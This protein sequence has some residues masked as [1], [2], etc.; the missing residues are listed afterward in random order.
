MERKG[1]WPVSLRVD[2]EP[3]GLKRV[4]EQGRLMEFVDAFST[5]AAGQIKA[6]VVEQLAAAGV[7]LQEAGQGIGIV[8]YFDIDDPYYTGPK[9]WPGPWPWLDVGQLR[10]IE[11]LKFVEQVKA[12]VLADLREEVRKR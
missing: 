6:Q 10:V 9:P 12:Q 7:G 4:V 8:A 2:I 11:Q 3:E 1:T 5:L